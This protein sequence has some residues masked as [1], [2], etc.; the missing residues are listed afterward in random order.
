MAERSPAE[1]AQ[2]SLA[3][4]EELAAAR[5]AVALNIKYLYADNPGLDNRQAMINDPTKWEV[6]P[7]LPLTEYEPY[8]HI[9]CVSVE[10]DALARFAAI[11][12]TNPEYR[13]A[14]MQAGLVNLHV[15][16]FTG[17]S[18]LRRDIGRAA[19][20]IDM[21]EQLRTAPLVVGATYKRLAAFAMRAGMR[22][23]HYWGG[24]NQF[25]ASAQRWHR[26]YN[27]INGRNDPF[28]IGVVYLPTPEFIEKFKP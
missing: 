20:Y 19:E 2:R 27:A 25:V 28:S 26:A 15:G 13:V 21:H 8:K 7:K 16:H 22:P 11:D 17:A 9:G 18:A 4:E 5:D 23:M 14:P 6:P 24:G 3:P 12:I 1:I 10:S